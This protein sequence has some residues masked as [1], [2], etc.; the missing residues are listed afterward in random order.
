[1]G[2]DAANPGSGD[3]TPIVVNTAAIR[4]AEASV[5]PETA[6]RNPQ[7]H[8]RTKTRGFR[9]HGLVPSCRPDAA[10]DLSLLTPQINDWLRSQT[11]AHAST[12]GYGTDSGER[13]R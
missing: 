5:P 9:R 6:A 12:I 2:A 3:K 1:M 11:R 13:A 4:L 10:V 7:C 8:T